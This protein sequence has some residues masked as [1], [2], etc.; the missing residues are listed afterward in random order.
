MRL[1]AISSLTSQRTQAYASLTS[2]HLSLARQAAELE[3]ARS[4]AR[5]LGNKLARAEARVHEG[6]RARARSVDEEL[7][8]AD[9]MRGHAGAWAQQQAA[10]AQA[11][12]GA[13]ALLQQQQQQQQAGLG[14][15]FELDKPSGEAED[16]EAMTGLG[17]SAN[18]AQPPMVQTQEMRD[19]DES[20]P[21]ASLVRERNKL[22]SDKRY[23][24]SRVSVQHGA[25]HSVRRVY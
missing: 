18:N 4:Q 6:E 1:R 12:A 17:I 14:A 9:A 3:G 13:Q 24:K 16:G 20:G 8:W 2:T 21:L 10:R 25:S 23:L 19:A 15:A 11:A 7:R 5:M 22:L